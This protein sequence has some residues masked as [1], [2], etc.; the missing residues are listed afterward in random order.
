MSVI[1]DLT[2][3]HFNRWCGLFL[4][5][6]EFYKLADHVLINDDRSNNIILKCMDSRGSMG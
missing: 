5:M 1:L 2:S 6:L 3:P 4:N